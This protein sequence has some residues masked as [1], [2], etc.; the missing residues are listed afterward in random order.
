[1]RS[2]LHLVFDSKIA[3]NCQ[4]KLCQENVDGCII[5][6]HRTHITCHQG[7]MPTMP[8]RRKSPRKNLGMPPNFYG[9]DG[10]QDRAETTR[11]KVR[12]KP[13]SRK[14][15]QRVI[16]RRGR[17]CRRR[18]GRIPPNCHRGLWRMKKRVRVT[19]KKRD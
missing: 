12:A 9:S 2:Q 3:L 7:T 17:N 18:Q 5:F 6:T 16:R 14:T 15:F 4:F 8:L 13:P 1:M 11:G 10:D 19:T